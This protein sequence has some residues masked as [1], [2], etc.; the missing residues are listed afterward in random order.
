[1]ALIESLRRRL[2]AAQGQDPCDLVLKNVRFLDVFS[3]TFQSG[4]VAIAD[5]AIVGIEP[6]LRGTREIDAKGA[7]LV[8]GFVDAHVHLESSLLVPENF[9]RGTLPQARLRV[10]GGQTMPVFG[11]HAG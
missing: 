2:R 7:H 10:A 3:C 5:G 8:P 11:P 4:D 6:G 9:Q 1:M